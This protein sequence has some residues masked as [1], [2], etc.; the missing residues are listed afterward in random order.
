MLVLKGCKRCAGD[1][2]LER[3]IGESDVVCLQCG[4]RWRVRRREP[5]LAALPKS[6]A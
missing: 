3:G 4:A 5:E 1:L 2:F 6:A